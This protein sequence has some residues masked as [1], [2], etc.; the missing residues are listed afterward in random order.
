[1]LRVSAPYP[2]HFRPANVKINKKAYLVEKYSTRYAFFV[3]YFSVISSAVL[4]VSFC[5]VLY[6]FF[7]FII[8]NV[9]A[10]NEMHNLAVF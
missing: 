9:L 7:H 2:E 4:I 1:M 10:W 3:Q 6:D 5:Q 8:F